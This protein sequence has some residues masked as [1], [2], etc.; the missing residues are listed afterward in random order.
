[1]S[2]VML[3]GVLRMPVPFPVDAVWLHQ[4]VDRARQAADRVE[5]DA[6]EIERLRALCLDYAMACG[7]LSKALSEGDPMWA[8]LKALGERIGA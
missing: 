8:E 3:L 6:A 5:A 1:M 4:F 2:D 7:E